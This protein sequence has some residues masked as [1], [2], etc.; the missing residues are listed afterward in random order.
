[1]LDSYYTPH[2]L[3]T[4]TD[5]I[6]GR[7]RA[8]AFSRRGYDSLVRLGGAASQRKLDVAGVAQR[9]VASGLGE[10]G[11][12]GLTK[13]RHIHGDLACVHTLL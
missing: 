9:S 4:G 2:K 10:T 6:E 13:Y 1:M 12:A 5:G 7:N 8:C 3:V 11:C